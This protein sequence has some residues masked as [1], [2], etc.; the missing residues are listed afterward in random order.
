MIFHEAPTRGAFVI[1][2]ERLED[3]RGFFARSFCAREFRAHGLNPCVAQCN[4]SF[5]R[6]R[7]TLRGL[8]FQRPPHAEAKLVRC[9]AGAVY[10]VIVDLRPASPTFCRHFAVELNVRNRKLLYVPEGFAHGFQ[11]L[12]EDTEAFYQMSAPFEP[13]AR[14]GVRWNDPA[15][16][17][18]WPLEVT[19]ISE[20]DRSFPDFRVAMSCGSAACR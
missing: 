2:P 16:A 18:A 4:I 6:R 10:D 7:G 9:T 15:F 17:I 3:E 19:S 11:T 1:E 13:E 5:N 12:E 14:A 20:T 8:H